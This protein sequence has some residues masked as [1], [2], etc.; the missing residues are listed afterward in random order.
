MARHMIKVAVM[1]SK[2]TS[3]GNGLF[4]AFE[5]LVCDFATVAMAAY[6]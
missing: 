1:T 4:E 2:R 6:S 3:R 5:A